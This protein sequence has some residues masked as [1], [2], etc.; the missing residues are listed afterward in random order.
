M[1]CC[2]AFA[3]DDSEVIDDELFEDASVDWKVHSLVWGVELDVVEHFHKVN[4]G[5]FSWA[6]SICEGSHVECIDSDEGCL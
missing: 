5:E 2:D 3:D 4:E 6:C 1:C